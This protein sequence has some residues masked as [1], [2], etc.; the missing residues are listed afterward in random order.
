MN[1]CL[2]SVT[3]ATFP[4]SDELLDSAHKVTTSS[5][6][7]GTR[8]HVIKEITDLFVKSIQLSQLCGTNVQDLNGKLT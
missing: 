4:I 1:L 5:F 3:A 2:L 8:F 7:E 6:F